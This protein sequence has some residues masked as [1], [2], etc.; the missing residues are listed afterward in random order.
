MCCRW[1][2]FPD[3]TNKAFAEVSGLKLIDTV[4]GKVSQVFDE[5]LLVTNDPETSIITPMNQS[6]LS[7]ILFPVK[8]RFWNSC[9]FILRPL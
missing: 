4:L 8:D 6:V 5:V 7:A 3:A 2:Q 1:T 9:R